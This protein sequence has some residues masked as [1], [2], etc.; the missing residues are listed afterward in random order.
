MLP[1]S[2]GD[3]VWRASSGGIASSGVTL[4]AIIALGVGGLVLVMLAIAYV[5]PMDEEPMDHEPVDRASR[6]APSPQPRPQVTIRRSGPM[7][8]LR[9]APRRLATP[10]ARTTH[11]RKLPRPA[12][13]GI[14][15]AS[16]AWRHK[17]AHDL[18]HL[19]AWGRRRGLHEGQA[20][21]LAAA[22]ALSVALGY[23]IV[24]I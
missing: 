6:K 19:R 13:R 11:A 3:R 24:H 7:P 2:S 23:L 14:T 17:L 10:E 18:L 12:R 1:W 21:W 22:V 4:I 5:E 20:G 15:S 9:D 16:T 8:T